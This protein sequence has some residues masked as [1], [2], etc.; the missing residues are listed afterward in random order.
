MFRLTSRKDIHNTAMRKSFYFKNSIRILLVLSILVLAFTSCKSSTK[1]EE[2]SGTTKKISKAD[3]QKL[4]LERKSEVSQVIDNK[5]VFYTPEDKAEFDRLKKRE[6]WWGQP[7]YKKMDQNRKFGNSV[8]EQRS[9]R[10]RLYD[11]NIFL[12]AVYEGKIEHKEYGSMK[13]MFENAIFF[14]IGSAIMMFEGAPTVR[15]VYEDPNVMAF[16]KAVIASDI[17]DPSSNKNRYVDQYYER[18]KKVPSYKFPFP[19]VEI[20][21]AID[22]VEKYHN[23]TEKFSDYNTPLIFRGANS[24]PDLYYDMET[25]NRHLKSMAIAYADRNVLYFFNSLVLFKH[26]TMA[27]FEIIGVINPRVGFAHRG[28]PWRNIR[29]DRRKIN[30]AFFPRE[31]Y[32]IIHSSAG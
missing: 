22:S 9:M 20:P 6:S 5:G 25:T 23:L 17:N 29:W 14:D 13:D 18:I 16:L 31:R 21:L 15:D 11:H 28:N 3:Y 7:R 4:Y 19:V 32:V 10:M 24:G 26:K 12:R 30:E 1:T 27:Q 2:Q 8:I